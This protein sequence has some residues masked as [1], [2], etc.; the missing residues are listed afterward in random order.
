[1]F[2]H[3]V[4]PCM[5]FCIEDGV[6]NRLQISGWLNW[7]LLSMKRPQSERTF[8]RFIFKAVLDFHSISSSSKDLSNIYGAHC[9]AGTKRHPKAASF[10]WVSSMARTDRNIFTCGRLGEVGIKLCEMPTNSA[11]FGIQKFNGMDSI[12]IMTI[13]VWFDILIWMFPKMVVPPKHPKM[14][15]FSRKTHGC[16]VPPF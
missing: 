16:W 7:Q 9:L 8:I 4:G 12:N 10:P 11:S 2:R 1:M 15:I 13:I 6:Y 5:F 14:I 3:I